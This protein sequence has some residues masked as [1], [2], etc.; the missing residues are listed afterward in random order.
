MA[1]K[2][3]KRDR[4]FM[5]VSLNVFLLGVVSLLT[6]MSS[7]MIYPILPMFITALGG[8]GLI[9]GL[10]GGLGDSVASILSVVSGYY[11]DKMGKRKPFIY[12]GYGISSV[13]KLLFAF[14]TQWWHILI[15]KPVERV[16]K[17]LRSA[18]RDVIIADSE[19]GSRG[20]SF[21]VHRAMDSF[22][23]I[24]GS[25]LV[26]I[27]IWYLDME[28]NKIFL[29]AG[30]IGLFA[31][32]PIMFVKEK[33]KKL[34]PKL[35]HGPFKLRFG[36][37]PQ[38]FQLF[39][40]I[41]TIFSLGNF[42]YMFFILKAHEFFSDIR[43]AIAIPLLLYV[44]FNISYT[45]FSI[46]AGV[47]SDNIGRKKVLSIGYFLFFVTCIGFVFTDS[48]N[49]LIILFAL[50]GIVHALIDGTARAFASDL[51]KED[52]RG[53][54]LGTFHMMTSMAALPSSLIAGFLWD[55]SG[56][57]ATFIYGAFMGILATL[58][59]LMTPIGEERRR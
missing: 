1:K 27:L 15:L 2:S 12:S 32:I 5:G 46:P 53:T 57:S 8:T 59:L 9:V 49:G 24:I 45:V 50:Y 55:Y 28:F 38:E 54:G 23:A 34:K 6:D 29:I 30:I 36:S 51:I 33:K 21:G 3:E 13:S 20:R 43:L 26:F 11:S 56:S 4:K 42:T 52:I 40:I 41:T 18:A 17:G 37:L 22:G 19:K 39:L 58:F 14:S 47:I 35:R 25:I 48:W 31:I 10:I 16:G 44:L 7:E